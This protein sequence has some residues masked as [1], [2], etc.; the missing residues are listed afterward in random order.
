MTVWIPLF[1]A[2]ITGTISAAVA[3]GVTS[4]KAKLDLKYELS[5]KEIE[6]QD[7]KKEQ[8]KYHQKELDQLRITH[9]QELKMLEM[10]HNHEIE[11]LE[12][13]A[14]IKSNMQESDIQNQV[15]GSLMQEIFSTSDMNKILSDKAL[16][17][18][19]KAFDFDNDDDLKKNA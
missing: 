17:E 1:S 2:L 11:K 6:K 10:S 4:F 5:K 7:A 3:F 19:I 9:Q 14:E 16:E 18:M 8:E 13:K 15:V 12:K